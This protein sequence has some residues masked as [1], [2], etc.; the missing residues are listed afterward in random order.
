[1][2]KVMDT[3]GLTSLL[4]R[5]AGEYRA[6][7]SI[8]EIPER[9]FS[10]IFALESRSP[11]LEVMGA[12][13]S[14]P[15]GPAAGPHTQ[16]AP[17][18]VAAWLAGSRV[19]ELKT[20]QVMDRLEIEKPC[21]LA[22]DEGHNTEW[23]TELSL[24]EARE[25]YLRGW[26][27]INLLAELWSP[28]PREFFFNMSVGYTLEGISGKRVDD[29]IEGLRSPASTP[30][31]KSALAELADFVASPLFASAFGETSRAKAE[32]LLAAFPSSPVHSVTLSTMHGCPPTEIEAIGKYL[33][34]KKGFDTY[35]KL[36]PT[37]LGY[38][39]A[40]RILDATGWKDVV[41]KRETFEHDLQFGDAVGLVSRLRE[42]AELQG[43]R[44]GI[45]LSNTLANANDGG[46]LPGGERYMSG[47]ALFPITIKLAEKLAEALPGFPRRF[48][49][50]GGVSAL[51]SGEL[52]AAGMGPLTV[53][54]DILKPGGYLRFS[55]M[56]VSV[57]DA[58][59]AER[60]AR[61]SGPKLGEGHPDAVRLRALAA[62]ALTRPEYQSGW[63][64]HDAY[65]E[66]PLPLFD[67][68]AAPCVEACPVNQKVPEY[69]RLA[70]EGRTEE[71]LATIL[72]DNPLPCITGT[73]CDHVCHA[74]CSRNDYEGPV[75]IR[76]VKL[77]VAEAATVSPAKVIQRAAGPKVAI[78]GAGPAGL[79]AAHFLAGAGVPVTVFDRD[80][81][82]GGV[83]SNVV[84]SFRIP[85]SAI[86]KD[87]NR[88][89]ALGAEFR[90][91]TEVGS[92][93]TLREEGFDAF[94][95]CTG[96]PVARELPLA[97]TGVRLVDALSFLAATAEGDGDFAGTRNLVVAGGGN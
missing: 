94:I 66:G 63:K 77:A 17:N 44:F 85:R 97:G 45:K 82:A 57:V 6:K 29:F 46:R 38:D 18:L 95:V 55:D 56:A 25:E 61:R 7:G 1:M 91:G 27:A 68:F 15:L 52:I 43:R 48:S 10:A 16:I 5:I 60:E 35:V 73:L 81:E 12:R 49:Y 67:C 26:I 74:A 47:R 9:A 36:N 59:V 92:L 72:A 50:C 24:D 96:A 21:I 13:V 87:I 86:D 19:F 41:V 54:T 80:R 2:S 40:R 23:S 4:G 83:V 31:W 90:F 51:N 89:E 14:L 3:T 22:L 34:E 64:Y 75:R 58:L 8:Y 28:K 69:I 65:I 76:E 62:V 42:S 32:K 84:P 30:F 70:A 33:I 78:I 71:S 93:D 39:E 20:V 37:L 11:G 88:I 79:A 53:A